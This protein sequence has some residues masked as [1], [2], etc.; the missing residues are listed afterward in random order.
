MSIP[1][2]TDFPYVYTQNHH[3]NYNHNDLNTDFAESTERKL[4]VA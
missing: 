3:D 1:S 4:Q 2:T